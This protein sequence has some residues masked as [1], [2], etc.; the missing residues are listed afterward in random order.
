MSLP[1]TDAIWSSLIGHNVL[2]ADCLKYRQLLDDGLTK[3]EALKKMKLQKPPLT[4]EEVYASIQEIW[5]TNHM[6]TFADY[7]AWY[8][9]LDVGPFVEAVEKMQQFYKDKNVDV[10]KVSISVPGI[11]C[12]LLFRS[13]VAEHA[14]FA[15]FGT[16]DEDL[17]QKVKNDIIG[18]PSIIFTRHHKV[19][20]TTIREGKLCANI[21]GFDANALYLWCLGSPM[22]VGAFR[23]RDDKN[24]RPER[25]DRW[26]MMYDWLDWWNRRKEGLHIQHK[27]NV[28]REKKVGQYRVDGYDPITNTVY[29]FHGC[30]YHG[31]SCDARH[32][33]SEKDQKRYQ[34]TVKRTQYIRDKGFTVVEMKE[35]ALGKG[36]TI[37][38]PSLDRDNHL[39]L[40]NMATYPS[41][42]QI[43]HT[44][45][46]ERFFG[47]IECNLHV[48]HK[49]QDDFRPDLPPKKYFE[50]MAPLFCMTDVPFEAIREHMQ[51]YARAHWLSE[52][53]RRL[54]VGGTKAE[55]LLLASPLLKW[56]LDHGQHVH[57][58]VSHPDNFS[59]GWTFPMQKIDVD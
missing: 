10:F 1:P 53:P 16:E 9:N 47:M 58:S 41:K 44:V 45:K 27:L 49:W 54:L 25:R 46:T 17:Y 4:K 18:G 3:A 38:E 5:Q 37:C 50:E 29:E 43:L 48:P 35:C 59:L 6:Q 28:E 26:L 22:T 32:H 2:E 36:T 20:D 11:A 34:R 56:Y 55:K 24:F 19:G 31:C 7:L 40:P 52:K 57:R 23:K 14:S 8:N 12:T 39:S 51:T 42:N 33:E 13:A 30:Y 15:L 21:I